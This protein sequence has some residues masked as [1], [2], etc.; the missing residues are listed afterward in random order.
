MKKII[1][2][3]YS[4]LFTTAFAD[5]GIEF[6]YRSIPSYINRYDSETE[7]TKTY[8]KQL[9]STMFSFY[10]GDFLK[11]RDKKEE[12]RWETKYFISVFEPPSKKYPVGRMI[13]KEVDIGDASSAEEINSNNTWSNGKVPKVYERKVWVEPRLKGKINNWLN[14]NKGA[15][16]TFNINL[17]IASVENEVDLMSFDFLLGKRLFIVPHLVHVYGKIGP[18]IMAEYWKNDYLELRNNRLGIVGAAGIQVQT[19]KGIKF[20]VEAEYRDYG[21][22]LHEE[23]RSSVNIL[24]KLPLV[25]K[26]VKDYYNEFDRNSGREIRDN[27][28]NESLRFG[29]RFT[30]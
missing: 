15:G 14:P 4:L 8:Y 2:V 10:V 11:G 29:I 17:F 23:S 24:N 7:S 6:S 26:E 5:T 25:E 27:L 30:F 3:L 9:Q 21:L 16:Y 18:S 20:Y 19:L 13:E 12:G 1:I 22:P 28:I